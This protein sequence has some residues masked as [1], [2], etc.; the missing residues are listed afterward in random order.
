MRST[1]RRSKGALPM[2][3]RFTA[4]MFGVCVLSFLPLPAAAQSADAKYCQALADKYEETSP[5]RQSSSVVIDQAVAGC[6]KG[7]NL[8]DSIAVLEKALKANRVTLPPRP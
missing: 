4:S 6:E 8:A 1:R 7:T 5:E 2:L 3:T